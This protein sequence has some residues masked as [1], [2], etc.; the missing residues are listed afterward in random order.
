MIVERTK[1][2]NRVKFWKSRG[3]PEA[4]YLNGNIEVEK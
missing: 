3:F 1:N 4:T 2:K